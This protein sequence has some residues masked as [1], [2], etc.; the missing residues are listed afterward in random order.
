V[1]N[2]ALEGKNMNEMHGGRGPNRGLLLLIPA[3]LI[4]AKAAK[5]RRQAMR[6]STEGEAGVVGGRYGHHARFGRGKW[7]GRGGAFRL[8]PR[9]ESA[10]DAW[11]ARAHQ[12]TVSTEPPTI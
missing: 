8:P 11:H 12:E 10:L 7:T 9:I 1:P 4:L 5:H 6:E 2:E 3:A